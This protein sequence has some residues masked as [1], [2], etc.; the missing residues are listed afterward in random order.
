MFLLGNMDSIDLHALLASVLEQEDVAVLQDKDLS[1]QQPHHQA[2]R[3]ILHVTTP[4]LTF[5]LSRF[6]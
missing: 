2:Q 6:P 4:A 3:V 5:Y 1:I